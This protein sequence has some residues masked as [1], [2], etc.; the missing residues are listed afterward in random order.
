MQPYYTILTDVGMAG[1]A[2]RRDESSHAIIVS[3]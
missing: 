1:K 3:S 2:K